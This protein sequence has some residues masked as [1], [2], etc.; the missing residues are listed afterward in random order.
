MW[1]HDSIINLFASTI[2]EGKPETLALYA[3][4]PKYRINGGTI[5]ADVLCTLERPDIVLLDI[6]L[7]KSICLSLLVASKII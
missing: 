3:D 6:K 7:K 5:P 2:K 4:I 1:R